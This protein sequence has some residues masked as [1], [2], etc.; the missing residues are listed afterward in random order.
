MELFKLLNG[1]NCHAAHFIYDRESHLRAVI[2][3]DSVVDG[4]AVGGIRCMEYPSEQ[5]AI[6]DVL[7]LARGM[8]FKAALARLPCGGAKAVIFAHPNMNR[9]LAFRALGR[10]V[11]ELG[12]LFHTGSDVGTTRS[13]LD[14]IASQTRHVSNKLEFGRHTA[15]GVVEAIRASLKHVYKSDEMRGLRF[16]VQGMG[17]VG[18]AVAR[19]LKDFGAELTVTDTL[20]SRMQEAVATLGAEGVD[21]AAALY[22]PCDVL[23]PCALGRLIS[24]DIVPS[25][26]CRIIA[27]S[28]NNILTEA[29]VANELKSA[30]ILYVPDFV[31]SAGALIMGV[32]EI[33]G[34]RRAVHPRL[35]ERIYDTTLEVIAE[36]ERLG[37]STLHA[38][39]TI[40]AERLRV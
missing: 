28:A 25:L 10:A 38:A 4:R 33:V 23:V 17:E 15:A 24:P 2:A 37:S 36:S 40:A 22:E 31:A 20:P 32:T 12:G 9:A 34:G 39:E 3:I 29:P 26:G 19:L 14:D 35:V 1:Y 21:P 11:D 7:R 8:S 16:V 27:G 13:D 5:E 6:E 30:G 18:F